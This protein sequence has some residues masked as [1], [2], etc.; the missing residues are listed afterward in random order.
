LR[1]SSDAAMPTPTPLLSVRQMTSA[2]H[3]PHEDVQALVTGTLFV[4][5]GVVMFWSSGLADGWHRRA[6][7]FDSLRHRHGFWLGF[8]SGQSALLCLCL[9]AHG[10]VFTLKTF[11]SVALLSLFAH[12]LPYGMAFEYLSAPLAAVLAA[13]CAVPA[14]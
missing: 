3:R 9:V 2:H 7:I 8:F 12:F 11:T 6:G 1:M 5:L 10:A 13:Y 14:C 4:A